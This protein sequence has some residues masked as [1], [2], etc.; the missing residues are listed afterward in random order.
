MLDPTGPHLREP[1]EEVG[2]GEGGREPPSGV[3]TVA[4]LGGL[5]LLSFSHQVILDTVSESINQVLY[6]TG[7]SRTG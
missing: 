1:F 6:G 7:A 3:P 2:G 5:V 4:V